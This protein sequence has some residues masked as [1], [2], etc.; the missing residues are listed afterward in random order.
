[1]EEFKKQCESLKSEKDIAEKNSER[2][3]GIVLRL[4]KDL[5]QQRALVDSQKKLIAKASTE[6]QAA[7]VSS[8]RILM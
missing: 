2:S 3:K 5:S 7:A 4:N 8:R 1:M 6:K